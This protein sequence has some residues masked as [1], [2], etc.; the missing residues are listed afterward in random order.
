MIILKIMII[1]YKHDHHIIFIIIIIIIII[2]VKKSTKLQAQKSTKKAKEEGLSWHKRQIL[3]K[4]LK[5][6]RREHSVGSF[7]HV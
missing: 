7:L 5:F 4:A 6:S 2:V 1:N 3:P